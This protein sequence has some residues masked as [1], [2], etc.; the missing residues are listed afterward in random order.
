LPAEILVRKEVQGRGRYSINLA[1]GGL[2]VF[3]GNFAPGWRAW[4]D[5][6]KADIFEANIFSRGVPVPAGR[7]EIVLRYLPA[8]FLWGAAVS[9]ISLSLIPFGLIAFSIRSKR[10]ARGASL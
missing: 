5:G 8:S 2:I 3:P 7:H 9:L 6:R 1:R 4:V 10:K